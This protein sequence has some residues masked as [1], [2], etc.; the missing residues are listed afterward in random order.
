MDVIVKRVQ[1]LNSSVFGFILKNMRLEILGSGTSTGIPVPACGCDI[2]R[3]VD[4]A[5]NRMRACALLKD[6]EKNI[7]ILI[8][9]GPEFRLQALRSGI[10]R[11]DALLV[12][13]SH[14]DHIH[15]MDD[16]RIFSKKEPL[17]IFSDEDCLND[18]RIRFDYVF[19]ETQIG[20]GKPKFTL[21]PVTHGKTEIIAGIPIT[22]VPVFHGKL[23]ITGWRFGDTAYITDCSRIPPETFSLLK[24]IK[25]LI[26]DGLRLTP[27]P[28]HFNFEQA[29]ENG[30]ATGAENVW[31]THIGHECGHQDS[32]RWCTE[33]LEKNFPGNNGEKHLLPA[34]DGMEIT[35]EIK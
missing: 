23:K 3:S 5:D 9:A 7:S 27:H 17:K 26:I 16:L 34:Y 29:A 30:F 18:I 31:F 25:N 6:I 22:P 32:I 2:C 28:T 13:H 12:T 35:V 19:K 20:G 33:W 10:T 4:P 21:C 15:G 1:P 8:D 14:A 11:V 24:G